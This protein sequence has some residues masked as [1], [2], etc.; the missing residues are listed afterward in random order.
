MVALILWNAWYL[1]TWNGGKL[2]VEY[3][4]LSDPTKLASYLLRKQPEWTAAKTNEAM[5]AS[6]EVWVSLKEQ[7]SVLITYF[8]AWVDAEGSLSFREDIYGNDA[9]MAKLL[10]IQ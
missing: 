9:K 7:L 5:N 8:T 2:L 6:K 10:F 1:I 3:L 4:R